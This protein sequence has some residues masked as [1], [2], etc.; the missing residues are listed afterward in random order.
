MTDMRPSQTSGPDQ[1]IGPGPLAWGWFNLLMRAF[2]SGARERFDASMGETFEFCYRDA[3]GRG[4]WVLWRFLLR[5]TFDM[6]ASG[7]RERLRPTVPHPS[8]P[9]NR[10]SSSGKNPEPHR[11]PFMEQ[12]KQDL[13]FALRYLARN[14]A[15]SVAAVLT[16]SLGIGATTSIFSVVNGV[17]LSPLPFQDQ[18]RLVAVYA[19][20]TQ[21]PGSKGN[22][23]GPDILDVADTRDMETLVGF[24]GGAATLTGRGPARIIPG[25]RVSQGILSTFGLSPFMG[26]DIRPEETLPDAPRVVVLGYGFWQEELG[27]SNNVL[28]QTIELQ[29]DS[30]EIVGVAPRGFDFPEGA[31][32]WR[33]YYRSDESCG[34]GCHVFSTVGRLAEGGTMAA[35][36]DEAL[37]LS[38][39]LDEEFPDTNYETR[40]TVMS[41]EEDMVGGIRAQL[42]I[43]FSAVALVLLVACANVA[44]LLLARAQGRVAEVGLRAAL[45]ARRG[46]LVQQ[47]LTESLVLALVGGGVGLGMAFL[48][49][50]TLRKMAPDV[51]PRVEEISVDLSVLFFA[52][53]LALAVS[54]LFGL[55]PALR[56][57]RSSPAEAL[58][59]S[60]R[61]GDA[62]S[63]GKRSRNLLLAGQV[64]L[65]LVLLAGAGLL[66]RTLGRLQSID[67]G[68]R[69]E[70]IT[71][72]ILT[73]PD[74][75]YPELAHVVEFYET[76]ESRLAR[77]PGVESVGSSFGAAL[78]RMNAS[79]MVAVEGEPEP[80]PADEVPALMQ[81]VTPGYLETMGIPVVR[82]RGILP[83]DRVGSGEV[84]LVN[85]T[86]AQ[87][88]FPG[89]DPIGRRIRVSVDFGYGS[90]MSTI[91]GVVADTRNLSLTGQV[92]G[93]YY[94]PQRQF[95][96]SFLTVAVRTRPGVESVVGAIRDEVTAMDPNLPLRSV[97]TMEEVV[98][99]AMAPTRFF[100]TLLGVFAVLAV[101]LAAVGL[102]GVATY[103]VSRRRQEIGIRMALGAQGNRVTG[104]VVRQAAVPTVLGVAGGLLVALAG[105]RVMEGL[106]FEVNP[107]DPLVFALVPMILLM[108][109]L[110]S[111]VLPARQASRVDPGEALRR[112]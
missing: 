15:F 111:T 27:G 104:M 9:A 97:E 70:G 35:A 88:L 38:I 50:R 94:V 13:T 18:D 12:L 87:A 19:S 71:R 26:R 72:F 91:V 44:N 73:L 29:G 30:Y 45:G 83:S 47:V 42:W 57:A 32:L 25:A 56:L 96:P 6:G 75:S 43:L 48:G 5:N 51:L 79:G 76:L 33:P 108:V 63:S 20:S 107:R 89:E 95:G 86:L 62:G 92:R 112:E 24:T 77:I 7:L 3:R 34:R 16:L 21:N 2:P 60:R 82:G 101:C 4:P 68:Y 67:P 99:Q 102:Y 40:F 85:Q 55:S 90:P 103:M 59:R 39:R 61:G 11:R 106:L 69:T 65:S 37:A 17:L 93:S 74:A 23:S 109:A 80:D 8:S 28:G 66:L 36:V 49:V 78:G 1:P 54:L 22:M 84:A 105:A 58:G 100:L 46:R 53:L 81:P 52:L 98:A 14:P 110:L 64:A 41:L 10:T 31:R